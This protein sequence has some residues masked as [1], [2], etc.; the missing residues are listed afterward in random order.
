MTQVGDRFLVVV[1]C[2]R[3]NN[4]LFLRVRVR[5]RLQGRVGVRV[6]IGVEVRDRVRG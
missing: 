4:L 2:N 1:M 3:G 5:V 6:R